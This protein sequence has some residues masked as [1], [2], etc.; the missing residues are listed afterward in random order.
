MT[1]SMHLV[2]GP[3]MNFANA[4]AQFL[5][6]FLSVCLFGLL[7]LALMRGRANMTSKVLLLALVL[8][9]LVEQLI[10]FLKVSGWIEGNPLLLHAAYPIEVG[11][12]PLI[13]LYVKSTVEPEFRLSEIKLRHLLPFGLGLVWYFSLLVLDSMPS[14]ESIR[15]LRLEGYVRM[16]LSLA[17]SIPYLWFTRGKVLS[18]REKAKT[19][20][21]TMAEMRLPWLT[22]L[23]YL[24]YFALIL[25]FFDLLTG[26][27]NDLWVYSGFMTTIGLMGL[28]YF[29]LK[30]S[31]LFHREFKPPT[32]SRLDGPDFDH[33][34]A[35]L[36][37]RLES[38]KL[39]LKPQ[40]RLNDLAEAMGV[41]SYRLSEVIK[42]GLGT[43]FYD[44]IN[45]MRV[46]YAKRLLLE[47]AASHLNLL[48]VA[49]DSGFNSKSVFNDAFR[50]KV[51]LTPSEF[52]ARESKRPD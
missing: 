15:A 41:K 21:S 20:S 29:A 6:L 28:T 46:E 8:C 31:Q 24:C 30:N 19:F 2:Y 4:V 26:P 52:R 49:M 1:E 23:L 34:K 13:Y 10:I 27:E 9:K 33:L 47:P 50:R 25:R 39:Y 11:S 35:E 43:T 42:H 3:P 7:M 44:L 32:N 40:F 22:F 37:K 16:L 48:G 51:G 18:L 38:E 5:S 45:G 12:M 14:F 36:L 17:I